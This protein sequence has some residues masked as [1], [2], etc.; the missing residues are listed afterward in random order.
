MS[1]SAEWL[2]W[3][4]DMSFRQVSYFFLVNFVF[5][6]AY[7]V[8]FSYV[9]F[10]CIM[11]L[12]LKFNLCNYIT[13]HHSRALA[14]VKVTLQVIGRTGFCVCTPKTTGVIKMKFGKIDYVGERPDMQKLVAL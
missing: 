4:T 6:M 5:I 1:H 9:V 11:S 13:L 7:N 10:F 2:G 14:V 8:I 3:C 12:R